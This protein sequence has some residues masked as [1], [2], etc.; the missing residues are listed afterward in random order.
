MSS[1][2]REKILQSCALTSAAVGLF[3]VGLNFGS[4]F[5]HQ[6]DLPFVELDLPDFG[7]SIAATVF[8]TLCRVG[9]VNLNE[10]YRISFDLSNRTVGGQIVNLC[11]CICQKISVLFLKV[12]SMPTLYVCI[13]RR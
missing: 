10:E 4:K 2:P 13:R 5:L 8:V 6:P 1:I 3:G 11:I 7:L 9:M 12:A